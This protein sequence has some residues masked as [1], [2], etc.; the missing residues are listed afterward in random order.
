MRMLYMLSQIIANLSQDHL[1]L[2]PLCF[3]N[4]YQ[5]TFDADV[6]LP[7]GAAELYAR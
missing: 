1:V 2:G 5:P 6:T 4:G 7:S 3:F